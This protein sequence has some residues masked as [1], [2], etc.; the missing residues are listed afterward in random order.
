[1]LQLATAG[2]GLVAA[3]A[4]NEA[5]KATINEYIK[6]YIGGDSGIISLVIYAVIV[7]VLAVV[8]TLQLARLSRKFEKEATD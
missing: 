4:W 5:I 2:F 1:M 7:T 8:I 6:P 3:L